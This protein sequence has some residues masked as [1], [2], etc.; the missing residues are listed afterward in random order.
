MALSTDEL[1]RDLSPVEESA[2]FKKTLFKYLAYWKWFVCSFGVFVLLGGVYLFLATPQYRVQ[3]SILIKDDKKMGAGAGVSMLEELDLFSSKKVVENEIEILRS[4]TLM[5]EVVKDLNLQ[6]SYTVRNGLRRKEL[7]E[8]SPVKIEVIAPAEI[9]YENPLLL[10]FDG[11]RLLINEKPYPKNA[12]VTESFGSI[13][14]TVYDS[15]LT[16]WSGRT[17]EVAIVPQEAVIEDLRESLTVET[18]AKG[19]SVINLSMLASIPQ[20]GQDILNHLITVYNKAA[21][22]DKNNLAGITLDFIDGRL[23][24]LSGD[25]QDA[26]QKVEE[27]KSAQGITDISTEA[28]LF[29]KAVQQN[30]IELNQVSIQL[31]VLQHIEGYVLSNENDGGTTPA[32]LGLSD[33]TL[34]A[35]ITSLV[36]AESERAKALHTMKSANPMVQALN[37][38]ISALKR[39]IID[40]I[41]IL[42]RSLEITQRNLKVENRRLEIM[43]Q[44]VPKKERE[45]VDLTRQKEIKNQLYVYLLSKREETAISYAS[46]VSDSRL[47]DSARSTLRPVKP[48][49]SIVL[50]LFGLIGLLLPAVV[51]W[52]LDWFDTKISSKE[53]IEKNI[54]SPV[55]GEISFIEQSTKI[56]SISQNRSKAA[57]QIRTLRTNLEFMQAGGGIKVVLITSSVSGEGKS[58]LSANLGAALAALDKKVIVL[59]FDLRKPGLHK[60]FGLNNE[61]GLSNY[62][63]GQ[64]GLSQVIRKTGVE[65]NM[66]IITCGHIPPNP[67]E[68]L[69]GA[70]LPK[71]FEELKAQYDYIIVDT[72]PVSLVSDAVILDR[73]A[74]VTVYVIRQNYTPKDRIKFIN[75]LYETKKL[76]NFGIAVN[77][78]REEKWHG[79]YHYYSYGSYKYYGK[80]YGE[81]DAGKSGRKRKHGKHSKHRKT[82]DKP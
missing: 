5:E 4:Y 21:I 1:F 24:L 14:T 19:T 27:Y 9:L 74:D 7:Y 57:E 3:A 25:L 53:E 38:Q 63:V 50:L 61:E 69:Q 28:E 29:L 64:A 10:Q 73:H 18:S 70:T 55:I 48:K 56:L 22:V 2:D 80:Y 36:E 39:N 17:M 30:D 58:F 34:L 82:S 47:I 66:D 41:Q 43:I 16:L 60:V 79:Y 8:D 31:D 68:L 49:K 12:L 77:G 33:P 35:L 59:G 52:V 32:T 15:L 11:D 76:K 62:L 54:K 40:N 13:R 42:R 6:V 46:T 44:S 72:P 26:E 20:R 81:E 23:K 67:Q 37:D 75:D 45:L 78:I 65:E 51:M 71:L